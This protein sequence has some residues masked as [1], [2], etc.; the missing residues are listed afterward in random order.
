[1]ARQLLAVNLFTDLV[2]AM[3]L[4]VSPPRT[5]RIELAREG[6]ETSLAGQLARDVTI[7]ASA[8]AGG[9]FAAWG[10]ARLT[11]TELGQTLAAGLRSPLVVVSSLVSTAGLVAVIQTP[12]ISGFFDCP[13]LGPVAWTTVAAASALATGSAVVAQFMY[14]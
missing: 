9:T 4:A 10:A 3:A 2:P 5:G 11:G 13:P 6:P 14:R 12:G 7:R 1:M 8:T